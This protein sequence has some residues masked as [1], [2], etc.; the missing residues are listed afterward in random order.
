MFGLNWPGSIRLRMMEDGC[1]I[2]TKTHMV[3]SQ[4]RKKNQ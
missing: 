1:K 4:V 3:Y 2:M